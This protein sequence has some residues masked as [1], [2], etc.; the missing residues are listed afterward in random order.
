MPGLGW[1]LTRDLWLEIRTRWPKA[2]WDD[3]LRDPEQR[4]GRACLRPE[5][6]RTITF[7]EKGVSSGQYFKLHLSKIQLNTQLVKFSE[8][9]LGYL[10]KVVYDHNFLI[11]VYQ[12]SILVGEINDIPKASPNTYR[13]IWTDL[14]Q[15]ALLAKKLQ[16]MED[17][18]AGVPRGG[19][20]GIVTAMYLDTRIFLAPPSPITNY[21]PAPEPPPT[22]ARPFPK[23]FTA[24][25]ARPVV[26]PAPPR[27]VGRGAPPVPVSGLRAQRPP[28]FLDVREVRPG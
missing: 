5:I 23:N 13:L 4:K 22:T 12:R 10:D 11:A 21:V 16:L 7:G 25:R 6:S 15:F 9:E 17:S 20:L 19:Y 18:K 27:G 1:M 28:A 3:W 14:K 8:L 26:P 2:F 24:A